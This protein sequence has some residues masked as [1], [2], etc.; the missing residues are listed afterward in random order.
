[1]YSMSRTCAPRT[2]KPERPLGGCHDD[3]F[4]MGE[5][6]WCLLLGLLAE[7]HDTYAER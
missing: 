6:N 4:Q 2:G 1:M 7:A 3:P 5:D